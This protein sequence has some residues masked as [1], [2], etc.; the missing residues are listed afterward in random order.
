MLRSTVS[1]P[2]MLKQRSNLEREDCSSI[3][4]E[5]VASHCP[6]ARPSEWAVLTRHGGSVLTECD[7]TVQS[8]PAEVD[9]PAAPLQDPRLDLV[10]HLRAPI[11][12]MR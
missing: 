3:S 8:V 6:W 7:F 11:F 2:F 12:W 10:I 1:P 4:E 9:E 5:E